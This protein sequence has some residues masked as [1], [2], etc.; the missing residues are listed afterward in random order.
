MIEL[1]IDTPV[2]NAAAKLAQRSKKPSAEQLASVEVIL[3]AIRASKVWNGFVD[4]LKEKNVS[5]I[6]DFL[7]RWP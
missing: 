1:E 5:T 3:E 6:C 7:V 2:A 4:M